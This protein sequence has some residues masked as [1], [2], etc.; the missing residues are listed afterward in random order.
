MS[1]NFIDDCY[2]EDLGALVDRSIDVDEII[3]SRVG[4]VAEPE[5]PVDSRMDTVSRRAVCT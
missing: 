5:T 1:Q 2:H 3:S 4:V